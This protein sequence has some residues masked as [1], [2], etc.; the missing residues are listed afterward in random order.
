M[1]IINGVI[2]GLLTVAAYGQNWSS[3]P[4]FSFQAQ[5]A[6]RDDADYQ[7]G[8]RELDA[9]QWE[10]AAGSFAASAER[11]KSNADAAL[12][13]KAY[14]Q[15]RS[16]RNEASLVTIAQ[17]RDKYPASR[18]LKDARALELEVRT[19]AGLPVV[20]S[21]EPDDDLKLMA[22]N[23]LMQSN[24]SAATP[25]VEKVLASGNSEQIK[26]QALFVLSQSGSPEANR[27][28]NSIA[29]GSSN[30]ALQIKAIRL[31][32]MMGNEEARKTLASIYRTSSDTG[33]KRTILQS[34]MQSGS[35][36]FL[37]NAA[38]SET[39]PE[40]RRDAIRQL[41]LS[42]GAEQ[43][44]Q[45]YQS[46]S[47]ID[48]K[49]AILHSMFLGGDSSRLVE[50]ARSDGNAELRAAAI[51]S[52]GLMGGNG[53][54]DTLTSIFENDKDAHVRQAVLQALFL[55]QNGKALVV[56]AKRE[57]DPQMKKEIVSKMALVHSQEVTDYM[58]EILR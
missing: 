50:I 11:G 24:P 52:L 1:R 45:L 9:R 18:W 33:V 54:A 56:L 57:R 35:R 51:H 5:Q 55:Q 31:M 29:T 34:F 48:D 21:A 17:L 22:V 39:N 26:E 7:K 4:A 41:A 13:W 38:K 27:L 32:G 47:S 6:G 36:D 58:M 37:L 23:T 40:L 30:P 14:A 20:A 15:N 25:V 49:K 3:V 8:L 10:Q 12:Y 2:C 44:W 43:L 42:G 19:R 16:G 53:R 28:L 46:T